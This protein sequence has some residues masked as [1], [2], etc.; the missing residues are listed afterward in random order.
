MG[1]GFG[2]YFMFFLFTLIGMFY[3]AWWL[4]SFDAVWRFF[5]G[6]SFGSDVE[7]LCF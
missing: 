2:G 4:W 5:M 3:F 1:A 7:L 6:L